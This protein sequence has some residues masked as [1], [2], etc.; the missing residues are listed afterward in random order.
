VIAFLFRCWQCG[1]KQDTSG[2]CEGCGSHEVYE[3]EE[4]KA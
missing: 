1:N 3:F 2:I 4:E